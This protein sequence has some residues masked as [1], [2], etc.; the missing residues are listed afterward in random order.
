MKY[1]GHR[2][3]LCEISKLSKIKCF[4]PPRILDEH[5]CI[6]SCYQ[7]PP[8]KNWF[9]Y[10]RRAEYTQLQ[11]TFLALVPCFYRRKNL[12]NKKL[13]KV[14]NRNYFPH[15]WSDKGFKGTV[16]NQALSFLHGGSHENKLTRQIT[17]VVVR[18]WICFTLFNL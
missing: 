4:C 2:K 6:Y 7:I 17:I 15:Y 5:W 14:E 10:V 1:S 12:F 3:L 18:Q 11:L 16:V 13:F 8:R 9:Q